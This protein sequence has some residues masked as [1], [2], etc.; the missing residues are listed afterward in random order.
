[1]ARNLT[2]ALGRPLP[3]TGLRDVIR[4]V[5]QTFAVIAA[6]GRVGAAVEA[7]QAP[8]IEDLKLAGLDKA[9]VLRPPYRF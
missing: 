1:V 5:A 7:R 4:E 8:S 6:A 9:D 2:L 3:S